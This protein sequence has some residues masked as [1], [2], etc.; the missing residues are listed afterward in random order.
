MLRIMIAVLMA[1]S[2]AAPAV[3]AQ[4]DPTAST[5]TPTVTTTGEAVVR[6]APD[7]AFVVAAV[8]SRSKDPREAQTQNAKTMT[9]V[10][11]RVLA[12]GIPKEAVRTTG[13][14]VEQEVDFVNGRRVPRGYVARNAVE[15]RLDALE[16]LG[17]LLDAAVQ[18]GA[19]SISGVRFDLRDR[20]A[21]E[22]DALRQAVVDARARAEAAAS[23]IGRTVDRV[24]RIDDA[25]REIPRPV[26]MQMIARREAALQADASTPIEVGEIEIHA[27]ATLTVSIK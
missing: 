1:C 18:A 8:E 22:R 27:Q 17:E 12:L 7:R 20:A 9:A 15:I 25:R 4:Q 2:L 5:S 14:N 21:A 24:L 10:Q 13:Y 19:T 23:G 16:R 26:P 3:G 11:A 6:R